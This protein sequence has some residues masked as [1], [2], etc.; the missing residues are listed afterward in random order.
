MKE[1]KDKKSLYLVRP[2]VEDKERILKYREEFFQH[3]DILHGTAGLGQEDCYEEWYQAVQDNQKEETLRENKVPAT[4]L[5]AVRK[6]DQRVVGMID[7]RHKMNDYLQQFG[8]HIGYSIRKSERRKGYATQMLALGL[9][10]CEKIGIERVLIMCD[11]DN[12][13]SAKTIQNNGG[14]L[15]NEVMEDGVLIQ[16]YYIPTI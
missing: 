16:R 12:I 3:G 11:K 1:Q 2:G 14:I 7:I 5:L 6:S 4:T 15:E 9:E 8:G 13:G 10:E